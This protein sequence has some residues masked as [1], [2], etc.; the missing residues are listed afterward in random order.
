MLHNKDGLHIKSSGIAIVNNKN[1][2]TSTHYQTGSIYDVAL[3]II[4]SQSI[5]LSLHC[6]V[7]YIL[8]EI[9]IK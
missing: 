4:T 8:L 5:C 6:Y 1:I 3:N 9:V 7:T 2:V